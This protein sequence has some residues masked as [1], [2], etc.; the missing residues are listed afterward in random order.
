[1]RL[2]LIGESRHSPAVSS[3]PLR[4][5]FAVLLTLIALVMVV[6]PAS[7]SAGT[8]TLI[9]DSLVYEAAAGE[10]NRITVIATQGTDTLELRVIDTTAQ[11]TASA[12][13][14]SINATEAACLDP[15]PNSGLESLRVSAGDLG[16]FIQI[17]TGWYRT[18]RV[19]GGDGADE[20]AGGYGPENFLDGG[21]G[22]DELT[23]YR[24]PVLFVTTFLDGGA[25]PDVFFGAG[26]GRRLPIVDYSSRTNPVT[27]TVGDGLANDGELGEGDLVEG[28][29]S[30]WGGQANDTI[31]GSDA[32][33]FSA[34][35]LGGD[36]TL[37]V[38][39]GGAGS[40]KGGSGDD[41]LVDALQSGTQRV[42][43]RGGGGDDQI[44]GALPEDTVQ[45]GEGNDTIAG[46]EGS[47]WLSGGPGA[48]RVNGGP[49]R[50]VLHGDAG[51]DTLFA[52]DGVADF[53]YGG[54]GHDRGRVDVGLD[55]TGAIEAFF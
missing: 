25:G 48:D 30:V 47:D 46:G 31:S 14:T 42:F 11:V 15:T 50:D 52:R 45:G 17:S 22:A 40:L 36:D 41:M 53:V 28:N 20:L 55:G 29:V 21:E 37:T 24:S 44:V 23:P 27:V 34:L 16:D 33:E 6:H 4:P 7:A 3:S 35:G 2:T 9:D 43:M 54:Q 49:R 26:G 5:H 19:E 1:M 32:R 13:C 51:P 18:A 8:V 38:N 39:G 10:A 12:G